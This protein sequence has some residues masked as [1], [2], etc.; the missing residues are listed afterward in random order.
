MLIP[1]QGWS[2]AEAYVLVSA[3][4]EKTSTKSPIVAVMHEAVSGA[5][6]DTG[7]VLPKK[8]SQIHLNF[9][10]EE[11]CYWALGDIHQCQTIHPTAWY[12]GSPHQVNFGELDNKGVLIVDTDNPENP[13]FVPIESEPL[14]IVE[15]EPEEDWPDGFLSYRG[16]VCTRPLPENAE[17]RA[18]IHIREE[19]NVDLKQ[20]L[21]HGLVDSLLKNGLP[22]EYVPR[23]LHLLKQMGSKLDLNVD[24]SM[25][26]RRLSSRDNVK[27]LLAE[28]LKDLQ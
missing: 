17:H 2:D 12:P 22:K 18:V 28:E 10:M 19:E 23:A 14:V 27:E 8:R 15:E 16:L 25:P 13:R 11:V 3:L 5:K 1:Y 6:T 4:L 9:F 24:I 20:G 26:A 21:F 7:F